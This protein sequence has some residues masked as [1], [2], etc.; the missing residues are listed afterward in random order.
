MHVAPNERSAGTRV[1]VAGN[2]E[3]GVAC[4]FLIASPSPNEHLCGACVHDRVVLSPRYVQRCCVTSEHLDCSLFLRAQAHRAVRAAGADRPGR[5]RATGA[6]ENS[7]A[8]GEIKNV[9][10]A[11]GAVKAGDG[12][13]PPAC[14]GPRFRLPTITEPAERAV[15]VVDALIISG[16][17][18]PN[19]RVSVFDCLQCAARGTADEHGAWSVAL[20]DP[21]DGFHM[22]LA[23]ALDSVRGT[24]TRSASRIVLVRRTAPAAPSSRARSAGAVTLRLL[25]LRRRTKSH[26]RPAPAHHREASAGTPEPEPASAVGQPMQRVVDLEPA[27]DDAGGT[28]V[29]ETWVERSPMPSVL[30]LQPVGRQEG[31]AVVVEAEPVDRPADGA[32]ALTLERLMCSGP[33]EAV[34]LMAPAATCD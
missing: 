5:Q 1:L 13:V 32:S 24:I 2:E 7:A 25:W 22:Y 16:T 6:P 10:L 17:A 27:Q 30:K 12:R 34:T 18:E 20:P 8:P 14:S 9:S 3:T 33:E 28:V 29:D 26:A 23:E 11:R 15:N 4:P 19:S 21:A 31:E